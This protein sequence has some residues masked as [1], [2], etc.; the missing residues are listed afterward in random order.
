MF[1]FV[2]LNGEITDLADQ[3]PF[4]LIQG[5]VNFILGV[6]EMVNGILPF[7]G[8]MEKDAANFT[9]GSKASSFLGTERENFAVFL[10]KQII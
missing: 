1:I 3:I 8:R 6:S 9:K 10:E 4:H 2:N 7:W 5:N